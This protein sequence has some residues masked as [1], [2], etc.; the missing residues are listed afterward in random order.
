MAAQAKAADIAEA[1][2][3]RVKDMGAPQPVAYPNIKFSPPA[4]SKYLAVSFMPNRTRGDMIRFEDP[5]ESAG[6]LQ[7][8]VY[9]PLNAGMI[10][11][12]R[13]ADSIIAHFARGTVIKADGF[14]VR[15]IEDPWSSTP[16]T[17]DVRAMIPVTIPWRAY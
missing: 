11:P 4:D 2:F 7:I 9:W 16:L 13:V 5:N 15:V 8:A 10:A 14:A 6:L 3:G 1:L 12:Q 17:D